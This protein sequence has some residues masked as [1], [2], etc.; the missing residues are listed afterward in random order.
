M[1]PA[2]LGIKLDEQ[3]SWGGAVLNLAARRTLLAASALSSC[4]AWLLWTIATLV[5]ISWFLP[6]FLA[7]SRPSCSFY[8]SGGL[9]RPEDPALSGHLHRCPRHDGVLHR[10][11][12]PSE[13]VA[14]WRTSAPSSPGSIL[15]TSAEYMRLES[16]G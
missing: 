5:N 12:G 11:P 15:L 6:Y 8:T 14:S 2:L 16:T 9:I 3:L 7:Y 13:A 1:L 4:L 10:R